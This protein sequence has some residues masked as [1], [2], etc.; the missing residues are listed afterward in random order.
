[1]RRE[2]RMLHLLLLVALTVSENV[3]KILCLVN[4]LIVI[5]C[6]FVILSHHFRLWT[7]KQWEDIYDER[8]HGLCCERYI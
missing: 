6:G 2:L 8:Y 5:V 3:V 1:M 7:N 4:E